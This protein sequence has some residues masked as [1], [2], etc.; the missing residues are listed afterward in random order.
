MVYF[1]F[2]SKLGWVFGGKIQA[3][4]EGVKDEPNLFVD[5]MGIVPLG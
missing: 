4:T 2:Q 3:N 5:A 1:L